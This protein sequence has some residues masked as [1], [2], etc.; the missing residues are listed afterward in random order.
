MWTSCAGCENGA[1]V[2]RVAA[3]LLAGAVL[4]GAPGAARGA[5]KTCPAKTVA[6]F[7]DW[8]LSHQG[9]VSK[10]LPEARRFLDADLYEGLED[11]YFKGDE[12]TG[13]ISVSRCALNETPP[14]CKNVN[15]DPF[16]NDSSPAA[17]YAVGAIHRAGGEA[18]VKV[19]LRLRGSAG[20][21]SSVSAVLR[22]RGG[23]FVITNLLFEPRGYYYAGPIVDLVKFLDA[24]NC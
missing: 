11:A 9:Q 15:Y 5:E 20:L 12:Y 22:D 3:I 7:Y 1:E 18:T 14:N 24:Y 21:T 10:K 17:S 2:R 19:T 23:R 4:L 6:A 16:T 13:E 8:Y